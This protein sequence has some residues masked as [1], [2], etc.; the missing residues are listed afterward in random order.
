MT[1]S[2]QPTPNTHMPSANRIQ[3]IPASSQHDEHG[4][5]APGQLPTPQQFT[6]RTIAAAVS[7]EVDAIAD[8]DPPRCAAAVIAHVQG[9][10]HPNI[11]VSPDLLPNT[12]RLT[13]VPADDHLIS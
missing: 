4:T 9:A 10:D 1:P 8:G 6:Q 3:R 2:H 13:L 7:P 11:R 5:I 12:S